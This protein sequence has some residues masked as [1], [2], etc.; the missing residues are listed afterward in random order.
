M[1][2]ILLIVLLFLI[3]GGAIGNVLASPFFWLAVAV[4]IFANVYIRR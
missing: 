4:V 3:L 2:L 1:E